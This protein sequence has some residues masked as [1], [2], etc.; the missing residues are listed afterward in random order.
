[1]RARGSNELQ[2]SA[3]WVAPNWHE[4]KELVKHFLA[5]GIGSRAFV[6]ELPG[7]VRSWSNRSF[8]CLLGDF[9]NDRQAAVTVFTGGQ[10]WGEERMASRPMAPMGR[11][12]GKSVMPGTSRLSHFLYTQ[13]SKP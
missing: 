8:Q 7:G 4:R 13:G 11:L 9:G 2:I 10:A 6:L 5:D 1:M 12:L 3:C